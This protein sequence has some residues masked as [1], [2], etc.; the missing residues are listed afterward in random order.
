MT[1]VYGMIATGWDDKGAKSNGNPMRGS[2]RIPDDYCLAGLLKAL[3][4]SLLPGQSAMQE[5]L[6]GQIPN[7]GQHRLRAVNYKKH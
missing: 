6:N 3:P 2:L 7:S 5:H 1:L 4:P